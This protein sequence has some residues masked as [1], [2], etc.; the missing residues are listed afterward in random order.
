MTTHIQFHR[1][2]VPG[3]TPD[4]SFLLEGEPAVNLVDTKMWIKGCSGELITF[5][6]GT[7]GE[8]VAGANS[9]IQYK[10]DLQEYDLGI[11]T[12]MSI[13]V[14]SEKYLKAMMDLL[15]WRWH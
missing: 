9:E 10:D 5:I 15:R 13:D 11:L 6:D 14:A 12:G 2:C 1:S 8:R 4:V 3:A 7:T